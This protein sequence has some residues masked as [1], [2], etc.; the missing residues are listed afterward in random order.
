MPDCTESHPLCFPF[1]REVLLLDERHSPGSNFI[2]KKLMNRMKKN[3]KLF[4]FW[5]F[6]A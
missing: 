1:N 6:Q 4:G 3:I 5:I 2:S